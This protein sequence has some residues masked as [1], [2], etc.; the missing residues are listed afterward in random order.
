MV[1][2]APIVFIHYGPSRYL[3]WTLRAAV[4]SNPGKKIYFLGDDT[5]KQFVPNGVDFLPFAS[6]EVSPKLHRFR[7]VFRPIEGKRHHFKKHGGTAHWL[8]FVFERW[9]FLEEFARASGIARFWTFDSDTMVAADLLPS[10][11]ALASFEA[12]EQCRGCCL[13]GLVNSMPVVGE[14]TSHI[15]RLYSDDK[16]LAAQ[17]ERLARHSGLA[18][19]EMDAWQHFRDLRKT[20]TCA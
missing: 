14:F 16:F 1:N 7:Q 20:R 19:N 17:S 15:L 18:F 2:D 3:W 11:K 12:T 5:N 4:Q 8:G 10:E 9:F 6:L 13:N